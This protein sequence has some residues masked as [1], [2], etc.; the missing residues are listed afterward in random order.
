MDELLEG[1]ASGSGCTH[2]SK[3]AWSAS[4]A[5]CGRRQF[6]AVAS[7][8]VNGVH[9]VLG[10]ECRNSTES[11]AVRCCAD[12]TVTKKDVCKGS[13]KPHH[14]AIKKP[15]TSAANCSELSS[16]FGGWTTHTTGALLGALCNH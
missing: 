14:Y 15:C 13:V 16:R 11:L 5:G 3:Y 2:D 9:Q 12:K 6:M 7:G 8:L 1:E 10:A 4:S